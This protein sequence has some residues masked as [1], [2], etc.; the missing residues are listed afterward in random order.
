[1]R[2]RGA[3]PARSRRRLEVVG[4]GDEVGLAAELDDAGRAARR[5]E[6]DRAFAGGARPRASRPSRGPRSR[7]SSMARASSPRRVAERLL[8]LHHARPGLVPERLHHLPQRS[9]P[10]ARSASAQPSAGR[11][12]GRGASGAAA[13]ASGAAAGASARRRRLVRRPGRAA[14]AGPPPSACR[15]AGGAAPRG[16]L[17]DLDHAPDR[18]R[19]RALGAGRR[20]L[21]RLHARVEQHGALEA[22]VG[23]Q[24]AVE[25]DRADRVVVAGHHEVDARRARRWCRRRATIGMP[26]RRASEIAMCSQP[27]SITNIASGSRV[28]SWMPS[29]DFLYFVIER[30]SRDRSFFESSLTCSSS[31][32]VLELLLEALD[33]LPHGA[34]VGEHAAEPAVVHVELAGAL[35]LALH[36]VLGLPLGGDEQHLAAGRDGLAQEVERSCASRRTVWSRS[37]MWM[38]SRSPK[39]NGFIFGFQRRVWWPKW[40]PASSSART[41]GG[42]RS[43][44][45]AS[46]SGGCGE[47]RGRWPRTSVSPSRLASA[48]ARVLP[49]PPRVRG[50]DRRGGPERVKWRGG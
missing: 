30:L 23:D 35:R 16:R 10:C 4:L 38:P 50:R 2:R 9:P 17:P 25:L 36:D 7:S 20:R 31:P 6:R 3:R 39:M 12:G 41:E 24:L 45:A 8:A 40:A 33:R 26:S 13:G 11:V 19:A 47:R 49:Y 32:T 5:R 48:P 46:P 29:S 21:L 22:R 44:A 43:S 14:L 34:E 15:P 18:A 42:V 1:M 27:T 37:M 28:I